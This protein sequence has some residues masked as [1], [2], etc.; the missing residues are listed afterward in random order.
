[1]ADQAQAECFSGLEGLG[2]EGCGLGWR[3]VVGWFLEY[4]VSDAVEYVCLIGRHVT[5]IA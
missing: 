1:M 5:L 3:I 2:F 4:Y